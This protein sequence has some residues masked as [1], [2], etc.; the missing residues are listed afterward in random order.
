MNKYTKELTEYLQPLEDSERDEVLNFYQEYL[1]DGGFDYYEACVTELGSSKQLARKVLAD[2]S[3]KS[4]D[5]PQ[6]GSSASRQ[7]RAPKAQVKTIWLIILALL[8]TPVTIPIAIV[9]FAM[10]F[11]IIAI[12]AAIVVSII[13]VVLAFIVTVLVAIF[14][15]FSLITVNF[16][17]G[18]F[19]LGAGVTGVGLTLIGIPIIIWIIRWLI[20]GVLSISKWLY[21]KIKHRDKAQERGAH[22]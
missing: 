16:W 20:R 4:L 1:E 8:S 9:V 12:G 18:M 14:I 13:A 6:N 17:P 11:A 7:R 22:K 19:Y 15:G 10:L 5:D 2:Y 21:A 3:I